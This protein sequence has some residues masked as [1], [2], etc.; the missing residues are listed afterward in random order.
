MAPV[1]KITKRAIPVAAS[2][3]PI[4][5][6]G[7]ESPVPKE[8]APMPVVPIPM[9]AVQAPFAL[10]STMAMQYAYGPG[11]Y[12]TAAAAHQPQPIT[13]SEQQLVYQHGDSFAGKCKFF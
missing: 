9:R 11:Y 8:A 10:D 7:M 4:I 1:H 2:S 6:V 5:D 13:D 3:S 12:L